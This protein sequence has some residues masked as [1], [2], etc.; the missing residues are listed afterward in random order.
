MMQDWL[1]NVQNLD[2]FDPAAPL[3][4]DEIVDHLQRYWQ[5]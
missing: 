4:V 2:S 1:T 5:L 3:D